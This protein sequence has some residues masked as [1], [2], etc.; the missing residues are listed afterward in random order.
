[1]Y[2][3]IPVGIGGNPLMA[4]LNKK[5]A[6]KGMGGADNEL[7][8]KLKKRRP[9]SFMPSDSTPE[10]EESNPKEEKSIDQ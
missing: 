1:M 5:L 8:N 7:F 10:P 6:E 4:E 2:P 3:S 9:K